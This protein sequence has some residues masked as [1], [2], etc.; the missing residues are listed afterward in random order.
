M[1]RSELFTRYSEL[2]LRHERM[3]RTLCLRQTDDAELLK[4][5]W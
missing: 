2:V 1:D 4:V 5:F 3:I